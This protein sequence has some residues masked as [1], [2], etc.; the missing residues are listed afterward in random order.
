MRKKRERKIQ[1]IISIIFVLAFLFLILYFTQKNT[2]NIFIRDNIEK[3]LNKNDKIED[4]D[5]SNSEKFDTD[6][7]I[8]SRNGESEG[9]GGSGFSSG[10]TCSMK[11]ISYSLENFNKTSICNIN[12]S[13]IC[14]DKTVICS[15]EINNLDNE[16]SGT[17]KIELMFLEKGGNKET[18]GFDITSSDFL[19]SPKQ[20]EIFL[21]STNIQSTG[22]DGLANKE[23]SCFYNTLEIPKKEIC[24]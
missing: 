23:I 7:V 5:I 8:D 21:H 18:D 1:I 20:S 19:L 13:G 22:E 10:S 2:S 3:L 4:T 11:Q 9:A 16:I 14:W 15:V 12:Q 6:N 17:F 24:F